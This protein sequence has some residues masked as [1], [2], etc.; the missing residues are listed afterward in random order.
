MEMFVG[1]YKPGYG[2][3]NLTTLTSSWKD[4]AL[5]SSVLPCNTLEKKPIQPK[6]TYNIGIFKCQQTQNLPWT[7]P[8][9]VIQ[10]YFLFSN[11][12]K[13]LCSC[14]SNLC[15][16]P[17]QA[18]PCRPAAGWDCKCPLKTSF[19]HTGEVFALCHTPLAYSAYCWVRPHKKIINCTNNLM[20]L[21]SHF[22]DWTTNK[23]HISRSQF[24]FLPFC[25]SC[26]LDKWMNM[27]LFRTSLQWWQECF[28][29]NS[30]SVKVLIFI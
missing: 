28:T 1:V 6:P 10:N 22:Q 14:T 23:S 5:M 7:N 19:K 15:A 3:L 26:I 30:T 25:V 13:A 27:T 9:V 18:L 24:Y 2:M 29:C 21:C 11:A 12:K 17:Q 20:D 8:Q 16:H 4:T